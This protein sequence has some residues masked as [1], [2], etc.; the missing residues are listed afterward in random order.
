VYCK[1]RRSAVSFSGL[2]LRFHRCDPQ[3]GHWALKPWTTFFGRLFLAV[4]LKKHW[5]R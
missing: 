2:S 5:L 4:W 1:T 3:P